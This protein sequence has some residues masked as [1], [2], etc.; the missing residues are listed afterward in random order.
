MLPIGSMGRTKYRPYMTFFLLLVNVIIFLWMAIFVYAKGD[1]AVRNFFE[2][3]ALSVCNVGS[4]NIALSMRNNLFSMFFHADLAHLMF[5]MGFLWVFAPRVE[6]YFGHKRFLGFYLLVGTLATMAHAIFGGV[7]CGIGSTGLVIGASGAI[8]GVM[9]A[10]LFLHPGA[11]IRTAVI[12]PLPIFGGMMFELIPVP[13]LFYLLF[14][15]GKDIVQH[16]AT[17]GT[18]VAHAAHIGGFVAGFIVLFVVA[19]F[20]PVPK[21]DPLEHLDA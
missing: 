11:R 21:V 1:I 2:T 18:G 7:A 3:Y 19:M 17:S 10:F 8:A 12:I 9:G 6:A 14:W 5:N 16:I 15:V 13:A 4:E 20:K